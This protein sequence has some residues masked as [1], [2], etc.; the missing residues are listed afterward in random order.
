MDIDLE[1]PV[2]R[3]I[4][5]EDIE[6]RITYKGLPQVSYSCGRIGHNSLFCP[7]RAVAAATTDRKSI[8]VDCIASN[9]ALGVEQQAPLVA[10][11]AE[12]GLWIHAKPNP[13]RNL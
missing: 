4:Q 10:D 7:S 3:I 1:E 12:F 13:R 11:C 2:K 9:P 6:Q 8:N 5:T